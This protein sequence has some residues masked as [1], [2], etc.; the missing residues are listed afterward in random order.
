MKILANILL[1]PLAEQSGTESQKSSKYKMLRRWSTPTVAD[2]GINKLYE[3]SDKRAW[4]IKCNHC[5]YDQILDYDKNIKQV[6]SDG[7]DLK[8]LTVQ[9]GTFDFVCQK[10]GKS[11][12]RWYSGRWEITNPGPGKIHGYNISQMN[13][14]WVT[15]DAL[16]MNELRAPSKQFFYNYTLG[17]PFEDKSTTFHDYD[18]YRNIKNY[19]RPFERTDE[20]KFVSSGIDWGEHNHTVVTVGM[21]NEGKIRLM[22][23]SFV[24]NSRGNV[25]TIEQD[26]NEVVRILNKYKPDIIC[27]D[28]GLTIK[29]PVR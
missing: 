7:V 11:L 4:V 13:A 3:R 24:P 1:N 17:F 27:P 18:V 21:T 23:I 12:D 14:V 8:S 28:I 25:D 16:K 6:K 20:Y 22:D 10:C 15:A 2:Y 19:E 5:G 9:P 26:L 29:S